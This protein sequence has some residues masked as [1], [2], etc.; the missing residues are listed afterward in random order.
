MRENSTLYICSTTHVPKLFETPHM[1]DKAHGLFGSL[2]KDLID[3]SY[4][5]NVSFK[6]V[7][8]PG[9]GERIGHSN[10]YSGCIGQVQS[11]QSDTAIYMIDYPSEIVNVTQGHV[12]FE[13]TIGWIGAFPFVE[14]TPFNFAETFAAFD[15]TTWL[16][17][18]ALLILFRIFVGIKLKMLRKFYPPEERRI[19]RNNYTHRIVTH[20]TGNGEIESNTVTMK[21]T[22]MLLSLFSF[23][24]ICIFGGLMQTGLVLTKQ[25]LIFESYD[26][27]M[28]RGIKPTFYEGVYG[29]TEFSKA[30]PGTSEH[31]LWSWTTKRYN[32]SVYLRKLADFGPGALRDGAD[33]TN[34]RR[35]FFSATSLLTMWQIAVCDTMA[36]GGKYGF[37]KLLPMQRGF[38]NEEDMVQDSKWQVYTRRAKSIGSKL[39]QFVYNHKT[40]FVHI[41][42]PFLKR[43]VE[44][45]IFTH[46]LGTAITDYNVILSF[47][48]DK[49]MLGE[50]KIDFALKEA[51]IESTIADHERNAD[52]L[53]F[54]TLN[55]M[56]SC[57][58]ILLIPVALALTFFAYEW[59]MMNIFKRKRRVRPN[60]TFGKR[61]KFKSTQVTTRSI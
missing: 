13:E 17:I 41:I 38:V 50:E 57:F 37:E 26:E 34:F 33:V 3:V 52:E 44:H 2:V 28:A 54:V 56:K 49:S 23:F 27:M 43:I 16:I 15:S 40:P 39:M 30:E 45:G 5:Y 32:E 6:W 20:F 4:Y 9:I 25:P 42:N 31:K 29:H 61:N 7:A 11:G 36:R 58:E 35:I 10:A 1:T 46:A 47:L 18:L 14:Y 21:L 60:V 8:Y 19:R 55:S 24:T 53:S 51:C 59:A 48:P 12:F 22:W